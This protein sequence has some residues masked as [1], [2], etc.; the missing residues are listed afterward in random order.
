MIKTRS[1][2]TLDAASLKWW[3]C[4]FMRITDG[5]LAIGYVLNISSLKLVVS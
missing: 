5:D 2:S 1:Q 3:L 4:K